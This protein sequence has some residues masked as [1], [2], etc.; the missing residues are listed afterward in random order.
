MEDET[1][2]HSEAGMAGLVETGRT[3]ADRTMSAVALTEAMLERIAELDP[4]IKSYATVLAEEALA[5]ARQADTELSSGKSRGPL[6]GVPLA[7]KDLCDAKGVATMAGIPSFK[8][9]VARTDSTTVK[10]LREAGAVIL[11][12]LQLTEGA[13]ALHHPDVAPPINPWSPDLWC[14]ASSSGSGAATAGGLCFGS[15]GSDTGG[16]IR[17]PCYT[18]HVVGL[19]PT[20]G[21]VSRFGVFPLSDTLDHIGPITRR[22]ED[23]AA[24]LGAIAG[25]DA[26]DPTTL[27]GL[28]PDYLA[29]INDGVAGM[30]IGYDEKYCSDTVDPLVSS[31]IRRGL[32]IL[33]ARGA[34]IVPIVMPDSREAVALWGTLCAV[35]AA[36]AHH[37]TYPERREDYS[38]GFSEFLEVGRKASGVDYARA[39]IVRREFSGALAAIFEPVDMFIAPI[40]R[41]PAPTTADFLALCDEPDGLTSLVNYTCPQDLTG[42][43]AIVLPAGF[44]PDGSPLGFQLVG[45]H[46]QEACLFRAGMAYQEDADWPSRPKAVI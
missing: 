44:T 25:Q 12:K 21:R 9:R 2:K 27:P 32:D 17:F 26:D 29:T 38:Q 37:A 34:D 31:S 1:L 36:I 11:G 33:G 42:H 18:H 13:L 24:M 16:S 45:H 19:K 10:R 6:H 8:D 46:Q 20:W 41:T 23:A 5:E 43:P 22:V 3:L 14:G 40:M 30:R 4:V 15:L 35:E 28:A 7:V 39:T